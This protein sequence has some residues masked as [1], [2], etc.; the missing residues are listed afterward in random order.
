MEQTLNT[1][2]DSTSQIICGLPAVHWDVPAKLPPFPFP[3]ITFR[4]QKT[5]LCS[6]YFHPE[7]HCE[8]RIIEA[9]FSNAVEHLFLF[10]SSH[11]TSSHPSSV[12]E[13][14]QVPLV[15]NGQQDVTSL[16]PGMASPI[17]ISG[18]QKG[19]TLCYCSLLPSFHPSPE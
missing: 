14:Q 5:A 16:P 18:V 1:A 13:G 8:A 10:I 9:H 15:P 17:R 11:Q 2:L 7:N 19:P 3:T 6:R 12:F 4:Q